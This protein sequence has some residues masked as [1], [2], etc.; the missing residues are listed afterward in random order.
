MGVQTERGLGLFWTSLLTGEQDSVNDG[1]KKEIRIPYN[2]LRN[3]WVMF[4]YD[5]ALPEWKSFDIAGIFL[6]PAIA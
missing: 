2:R 4:Y 5:V 6:Y 3:Q 1:K